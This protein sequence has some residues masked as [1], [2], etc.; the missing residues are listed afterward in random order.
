MLFHFGRDVNINWRHGV[1]PLP[2]NEFS[3]KGRISIVLWGWVKNVIEEDGNPDVLLDPNSFA[4]RKLEQ[5]EKL[6]ENH[7]TTE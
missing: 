6:R 2:K 5:E 3:G 4:A 7:L 1:Q